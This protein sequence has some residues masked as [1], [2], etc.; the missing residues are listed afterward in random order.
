MVS[1]M[2]LKRC[3]SVLVVEIALYENATKGSNFHLPL[4]ENASEA[5]SYVFC[6]ALQNTVV[7]KIEVQ[8][9]RCCSCQRP[10]NIWGLWICGAPQMEACEYMGHPFYQG[11]NAIVITHLWVVGALRSLQNPPSI[12]SGYCKTVTVQ[13][14]TLNCSAIL[15]CVAW[16][17][18]SLLWMVAIPGCW[19]YSYLVTLHCRSLHISHCL[20]YLDNWW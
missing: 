18:Y 13:C 11:V 10:L 3:V 2:S 9:K 7:R 14:S 6:S 8:G 12:P 5:T 17:S 16:Y 15:S 1:T 20:C 4:H 19:I